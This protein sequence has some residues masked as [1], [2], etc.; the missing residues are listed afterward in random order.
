MRGFLNIFIVFLSLVCFAFPQ[1]KE[2]DEPLRVETSLV[3][4]PTLVT[5]KQNRNIT[6]LKKED[7]TIFE[8]G[9]RQEIASFE[10]SN[11]PYS[12]ALVLDISDSAKFKLTNIKKAA[13]V[14]L[15]QL[16]PQ[17]KVLIFAFNRSLLKL[18]EGNAR[19][20]SQA[21][22][23]INYPMSQGSTSL[24]DSVEEVIGKYMGDVPGKK[25][26]ILFTDGIDTSSRS[27]FQSSLRKAKESSAIIYSIQYPTTGDDQRFKSSSVVL[28]TPKGEPLSSAYKRGTQYLRLLS[29]NSNGRF[30]FADSPENLE[31]SFSSIAKE[32]SQQYLLAYYPEENQIKSKTKKIKVTVGK[33]NVVVK[34]RRAYRP[35]TYE[36]G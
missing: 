7:F 13:H 19:D 25:A 10:D 31:D 21:E 17:D 12:I 1:T 4:V 36:Q 34:T 29:E 32:L 2:D 35:K 23:A 5:D 28:V 24:Y 18:S 22:D 14:F 8:D 16:R 33:P 27:T 3:I 11:A 20:L 9:I 26:I 6:D 15:T 30:Y